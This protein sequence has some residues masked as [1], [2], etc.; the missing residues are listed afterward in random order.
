MVEEK[1]EIRMIGQI[2]SGALFANWFANSLDSDKPT[3]SYRIARLIWA[4]VM[5]YF[6]WSIYG[7]WEV[8]PHYQD[9]ALLVAWGTFMIEGVISLCCAVQNKYSMSQEDKADA[10]VIKE[11]GKI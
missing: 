4:G 3:K 9:L 5:F 2:V 11:V 6:A 1:G 7:L 8:Y 10:W